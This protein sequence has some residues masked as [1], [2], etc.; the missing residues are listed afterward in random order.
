MNKKL[1]L[2]V[3]YTCNNNCRF[4]VVADK[5]KFGDLTTEELKKQMEEG[6]KTCE[7]IVFTGGEATIRK[8]IIE[9][10]RYAKKLKFDVI[11]IQTN[12]RMFCSKKF[13]EK[14]IKAG[15]NEFSPAL[16]GHIAE[17]HDYLTRAKGSFKQTVKGI[18]NLKSLKQRVITNT[19]VTK[20]NYR[21][22]PKIASL[23]VSLKVD[24][25]QFAFV[26]PMGNAW[27]NFDNIVP[28]ISLAAPYI[29]KGLDIGV[30]T[31]VKCMAEA[32]PFCLMQGYEKFVSENYMPETEIR[33]K[34]GKEI[35]VTRDFTIVRKKAG[36]IKFEKC[37]DCKYY[38]VCEGP[39]EEYPKKRGNKEFTPVKK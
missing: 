36:K 25:F 24:Q 2:K 19:V 37:K 33:E 23:L 11:Q 8:D 1:D 6:R 38:K 29:K 10:V 14:I 34:I 31:G 28:W 30:L 7:D 35:R 16:H 3:G 4:C 5:R 39:W 20:P 13:C 18:K 17:L 12:G 15:A 32:M 21:Y 27:E 22:L 9:L 26:H